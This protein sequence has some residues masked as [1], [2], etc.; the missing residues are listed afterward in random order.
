[1]EYS[2]RIPLSNPKRPDETHP[3]Q[4]PAGVCL[5]AVHTSAFAA[6]TRG[7]KRVE[8]K[9]EVAA[10]EPEEDEK[11]TAAVIK[12]ALKE[13]IDDLGGSFGESATRQRYFRWRVR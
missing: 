12:K 2:G 1:M 3:L 13:L 6:E 5:P 9:T 4:A 11:V 7:V 8:I 10:Y